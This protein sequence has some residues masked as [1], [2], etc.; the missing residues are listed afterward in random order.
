M[1]VLYDTPATGGD[2]LEDQGGDERSKG[3][4]SQG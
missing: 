4:V 3:Q 1:A 2:H